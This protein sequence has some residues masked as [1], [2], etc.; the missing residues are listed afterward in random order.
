MNLIQDRFHVVGGTAVSGEITPQGNENEALPVCAAACLTDQP[1]VLENLPS[2]ADVAVM[3]EILRAL[4]VKVETA[5]HSVI[6]H[7][8]KDPKSDL[9][10][11]LCSQLRGSV[12]LA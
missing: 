9:P 2:I 5:G 11:A 7:A 4:G 1:V 10:A 12:T 8:A 6:V 3:Q